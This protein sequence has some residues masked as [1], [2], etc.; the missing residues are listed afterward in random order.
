MAAKCWDAGVAF[1]SFVTMTTGSDTVVEAV[2]RGG[3]ADG[4]LDGGM[5]KVAAASDV[6]VILTRYNM[7]KRTNARWQ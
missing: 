1:V 2:G 7:N 6:D 3:T 5:D 4:P